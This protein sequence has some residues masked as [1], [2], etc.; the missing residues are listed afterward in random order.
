VYKN[1]GS[2]ISVLLK[3]LDKNS[4]RIDGHI[5]AKL[6]KFKYPNIWNE[7]TTF[8]VVRN[9]WDWQISLFHYMKY[10]THHYQYHIVK[11]MNVNDY[12]LWRKNDLHQQLDFIMDH[13]GKKIIDY[14]IP[15]DNLNE[16]LVDFFKKIY[17]INISKILPPK[18]INYSKRNS[19]YRSYYNNFT[20]KLVQEMHLPDIEYFGFTF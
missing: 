17:K 14:I 5:E 10:T 12:L 8:C 15:F 7:Y 16:N 3:I 4:I 18:K 19:N 11:N 6:A 20:K 2:Y 13:D 9:S 1:A